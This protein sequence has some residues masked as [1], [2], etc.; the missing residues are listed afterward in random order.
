MELP[1]GLMNKRIL[2]AN[3]LFMLPNRIRVWREIRAWG[4]GLLVRWRSGGESIFQRLSV[5]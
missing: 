4:E 1:L 3:N 5:H 2:H